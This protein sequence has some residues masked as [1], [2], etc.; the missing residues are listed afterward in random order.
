MKKSFSLLLIIAMVFS[1]FS[2]VAFAAEDQSAGEFLEEHGIIKGSLSGDLME[3]QT[4]KRQDVTVILARLLGAEDEAKDYAKTHTFADVTDPYYDGFIS[5][6]KDE[7]LF[8]GHSDVR[9]GYNE[10]ISNQQFL[11]VMLR[12]LGYEVAYEEVIENAVE[13]GLV[14]E[15]VDP[16]EAA[17]RGEYFEI[18]VTTLHTK[19]ADGQILGEKLGILE[20][21]TLQVVDVT[22]D[23]L[24]QVVVEF[25]QDVADNEAVA[26][27]DNYSFENEDEDEV[28]VANV[29]V[30]GDKAIITLAEA[31]EQQSA[32]TL[33]V[34]DEILA[35][36]DN[37]EV[38]FF[39]S[40]VPEVVS[41]EVIG[42]D[43]IKVVFSEPIN[44]DELQTRTD[45]REGFSLTNKDG[46]K[47]FVDD[48]TFAKNDTEANVEFYTT[49]EE[50]TYT[51]KVE[52]K[53][54]DYAGF[55]VKP[56]TIDLDVVVD[57]AEP[58]IVGYKDAKP[59]SVT[60]I[61]DADI[62]V[63][64][65]EKDFYHTNKK[66]TVADYELDGN[67]L[68][69]KF[70]KDNGMPSGT[71]YV[72]VADEAVQDL[73]DNKNTQ[74]LRHEIEVTGDNEAPVIEEVEV[75]DQTKIKVHFNEEL[76]RTTAEDEDNYQLFDEDGD[77]LKNIVDAADLNEDGDVVTLTLDEDITGNVKLVVDDVEDIYGNAMNKVEYKFF[78]EDKTAPDHTEFK[79]TLYVDDEI[80][81]LVI[82]F[83]G[84]AMA[85]DGAYSVLDLDKYLVRA[86]EDDEWIELSEL[87]DDVNISAVDGDE[88]VEIEIDTEDADFAF[89]NPGS[90]NGEKLVTVGRVADDAG[91]KMT[92]LSAEIPVYAP[93]GVKIESVKAV[94]EETIEVVLSDEL[95]TLD[96]DEFK[97]VYTVGG[98]E[99][100]I[101]ASID[102]DYS[103]K[104][105]PK[106]IFRLDDERH[107]IDADGTV[108][109]VSGSTKTDTG[110][111]ATLVVREDADRDIDSQNDFGDKVVE[112][113]YEVKDGIKPEIT[114]VEQVT[115]QA[116]FKVTVSEEVY[117]TTDNY[118]LL[119]TDFVV[120]ADDDT[121]VAGEDYK[122]ELNDDG[123]T[124]TI[125]IT[126]EK[127]I[128]DNLDYTISTVAS[129]RYLKDLNGNKLAGVEDGDEFDLELDL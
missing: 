13:L 38:T 33:T 28:E 103:D 104:D 1:M 115:G 4:W 35:E 31:Q 56:E 50:T 43:T 10:E 119:A 60:L 8:Q 81:K 22:A 29:D 91:N 87:E 82:D 124:L 120:I 74:I 68:T 70:D 89:E 66:N 47:I 5:W 76:D 78:A 88:K 101:V 106:L 93:E 30:D 108:I 77:E 107:L 109:E 129:P 71:V 85:T 63:I 26:D 58:E 95:A 127:Y 27:E 25:N 99:K 97:L 39:D 62:E 75:V 3:D 11:A 14:D 17:T 72:Y 126:N 69:L 102:E 65:D 2:S 73:W 23:N 79:A 92:V 53:Y 84:D 41:A 55:K 117:V 118:D 113:S 18:I 128:K 59:Y 61:F 111:N 57:D 9:F 42:K 49:F 100:T 105:E 7:G 45:R 90:L 37:F 94:D 21:Q 112:G 114:K 52:N 48:V 19:G 96:D 32:L 86:S 36:E 6:A 83:G 54:E 40:T 122:V 98:N 16:D 64:G 125:T 67:E 15:G 20:P 24:I 44:T 12:A 80:Q 110:A 51:L 121:L 123:K 34:S 46:K 116:A